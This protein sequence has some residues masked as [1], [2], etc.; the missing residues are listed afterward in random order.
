[1]GRRNCLSNMFSACVDTMQR[2]AP[3]FKA[4]NGR[5]GILVL[6][7]ANNW[8][9]AAKT[10]STAAGRDIQDSVACFAELLV[11][12][13]CL[14]DKNHQLQTGAKDVYRLPD[15]PRPLWQN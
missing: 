8:N 4:Q 6:V 14:S 13:T 7:L 3:T 12:P 5:E 11:C 10:K 1:M 9:F 15:P 2:C